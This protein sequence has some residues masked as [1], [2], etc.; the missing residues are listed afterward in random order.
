MLPPFLQFQFLYG[1]IK[2]ALFKV[3]YSFSEYFNSCMV[4]LRSEQNFLL[5]LNTQSFQFLYGAIKVASLKAW[6]NSTEKFQFLYG[7]IKVM[8]C[9][10]NTLA[11]LQFQFLY[12]AIKVRR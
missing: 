7:A 4:R 3:L 6:I 12:G 9:H 8:Q 2:V 11:Y 1:A 5:H 10:P